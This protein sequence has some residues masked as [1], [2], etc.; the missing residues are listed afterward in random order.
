M[1]LAPVAVVALAGTRGA[2][3]LDERA[4][5]GPLPFPGACS[6]TE[7]R[8]HGRVGSLGFVAFRLVVVR[9][10]RAVLRSRAAGGARGTR[11][12]P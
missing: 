5:R 11:V 7:S 9:P 2:R 8:V 1:M 4:D 10:A 3:A 12:V 6:R